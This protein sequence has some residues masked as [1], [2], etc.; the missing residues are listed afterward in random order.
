MVKSKKMSKTSIAV[1]VLAIMLV[2]SLVLG[3]TGAWYTNKATDSMADQTYTFKMDQYFNLTIGTQG[4]SSLTVTRTEANGSTTTITPETSGADEGKYIVLPGDDIAAAAT[5]SL[6]ITAEN[7]PREFYY[8]YKVTGNSS[9]ADTDWYAAASAAASAAGTATAAGSETYALLGDSS[10]TINVASLIN[11]LVTASN[12]TKVELVSGSTYQVLETLTT[13]AIGSTFT[14]V[15]GG[16]SIEVRT[17]QAQN[18]TATAAY[19]ALTDGF[20]AT[21]AYTQPAA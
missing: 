6:T 15:V 20:T 9:A 12:N 2:F 3:L 21:A 16:V 10:T 13:E 8:V 17:I 7:A 4:S 11:N 1:I 14:L 18:I 19:T 5:T